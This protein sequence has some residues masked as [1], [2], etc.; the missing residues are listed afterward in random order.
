MV[1]DQN[2]NMEWENDI[3]PDIEEQYF[4]VYD[5]CLDNKETLY[6]PFLS[7]NKDKDEK[8]ITE[9]YFLIHRSLYLN[10]TMGLEPTISP[11]IRKQTGAFLILS[12]HGI[13]LLVNIFSKRRM[14]K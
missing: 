2:G 9:Q 7:I 5:Y 11:N 14:E 8:N 3:V 1:F 13:V 6:M 12:V 4:R 10:F